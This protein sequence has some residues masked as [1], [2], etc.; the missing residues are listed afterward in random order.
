MLGLSK[1]KSN[2]FRRQINGGS[3]SSILDLRTG[4]PRFGSRTQPMF[5]PRIDDSHC[6]RIQSSFTWMIVMMMVVSGKQPVAW[7][8]YFA[9]Y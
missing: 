5:F 4:G 2:F 6:D 9:E 1:L 3:D 7:E 8:E